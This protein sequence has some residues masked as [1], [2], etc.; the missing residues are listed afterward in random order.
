MI[1]TPRTGETW[2]SR[3]TGEPVTITDS[4]ATAIIGARV[5]H[6]DAAGHRQNDGLISFR[7]RYV[8]AVTRPHPLDRAID[9][10]IKTDLG[11]GVRTDQ[12]DRMRLAVLTWCASIASSGGDID[13]LVG[14]A[15]WAAA[16]VAVLD[17][18][19]AYP[20]FRAFVG[21]DSGRAARHS[22][23]GWT[24]IQ[25]GS[26]P[27]N[28]PDEQ[29]LAAGDVTLSQRVDVTLV[30][31]LINT[32]IHLL[33]ER[34][35]SVYL[36]EA[37]VFL[38]VG[39]SELDAAGRLAREYGVSMVLFN[40]KVSEMRGAG[41]EGY[42]SRS[43]ILPLKDRVEAET[44]LHIAGP[45]LVT[46]ERL[47]RLQARAT[48]GEGRSVVP[49]WESMRHL[50]ARNGNGG[51]VKNPDGS[52]KTVRGAVAYYADLDGHCVPV[53][54]VLPPEFLSLSTTN[55]GV[56]LARRRAARAGSGPGGILRRVGCERENGKRQRH[57]ARQQQQLLRDARQR[58]RRPARRGI[59]GFEGISHVQKNSI[60]QAYRS[61]PGPHGKPPSAALPT[62]A[63]PL[64][65][66]K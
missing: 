36:D 17:L 45:D 55:A 39:R 24:H 31:A 64:A 9:G 42:F 4:Y 40:Q 21:S 51:T 16:W 60:G 44:A 62:L 54:I 37:W 53:E 15:A 20:Q 63:G 28:L 61:L 47:T 58:G 46:P 41:L 50:A 66:R 43:L 30:R 29:A 52:D 27:L 65:R 26:S 23:R 10:A 8:P 18:A 59:Q 56:L 2:L 6:A 7:A 34:G 5:A 32:Y 38:L 25:V 33:R 12:P 57:R 35:G 14:V 48:K 1:I 3:S 19:G 49:N 11:L 13:D 22:L